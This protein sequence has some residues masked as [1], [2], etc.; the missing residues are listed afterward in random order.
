MG[1]SVNPLFKELDQFYKESNELYHSIALRA[2][3]SDSSF[4]VLYYLWE[5]GDGCLQRDICSR[6]FLSKQ[7]IHS[8]VCKLEKDEFL[9][10]RAGKGRDM[11]LSLTEKGNAFVRENII[12]VAKAENEALAGLTMQEQKELVRLNQKYIKLLRSKTQHLI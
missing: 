12:P 4:M 3:I 11:H 5:L 7:T 10:L 2:G 9:Q 6:C 8:A 1:V